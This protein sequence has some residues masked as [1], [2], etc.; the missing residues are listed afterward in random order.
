MNKIQ[1][2]TPEDIKIMQEGGKKL[3]EV[4]EA[5]RKKVAVGINAKQIDDLAE[6]L[7]VKAK[8]KPS[9]KMVPGYRWTTC[10]NVN[11]GLVHGIPKETLVFKDKDLVSIDVGLFYKG[12]HLD[13]SLST[14]VG[15][16]SRREHFL[17]VGKE[18]LETSIKAVKIGDRIYDISEAMENSLKAAGYSPVRALV[19]HG[20][21]R[22]LHEEPQI[23]CFVEGQDRN[24]SPEIVDGLVIAIE[25]MYTEGSGNVVLEDDGW[26]ISSSD[27]K[28]SG[29]F[30]ETVAVTKN[31]IKVLTR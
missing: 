3:A 1:L 5:L 21:G 13:T 11:A 6:D 30:E 9:F 24:F 20:V 7:I 14:L 23:P 2:K 19:G 8:A 16:D 12:F 17:Q 28:I 18:T 26:T 10:V 31:G 15:K 22:E 29:L 27:G 25:V 4:K